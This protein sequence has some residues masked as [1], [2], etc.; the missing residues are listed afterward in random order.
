[1]KINRRII[2]ALGLSTVVFVLSS[3]SPSYNSIKRMQKMEEG[4]DNPTTKEELAEALKKY[5]ARAMDLV[6]TEAQEGVWYKILGTRYLDEQMYGK[7][8][9]SFQKALLYYPNNANLYYYVGICAGY[10]ANTA[11]DYNAKGTATVE[12]TKQNYLDL[13]EKSYLQALSINPNYYRALYGIGVLY[14]FELNKNAEAIP[15]LERFLQTQT[16]DTNAMFVLARAYYSTYQFEKA[17]ELYDKIIEINPNKEKTSEA[18]SN[19]KI[20]LDAQYSK[21]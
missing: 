12:T 6:Q 17:L 4:V 13:S 10:M 18:Q 1:M 3:C 19:K 14:V 7:A 2:L 11:L 21:N 9:E 16:R 20:V 5:D 15:Y 8:L